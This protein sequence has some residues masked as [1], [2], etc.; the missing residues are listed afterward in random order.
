MKLAKLRKKI[1]IL[2]SKGR[3]GKKIKHKEIVKMLNKLQAKEKQIKKM[4]DRE[5]SKKA[6][7]DLSLK[8]KTVRAQI[9]KAR[10]LIKKLED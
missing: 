2:V 1:K 4:H 3:K 10:K 7:K 8:L 5:E 6:Q 9:N